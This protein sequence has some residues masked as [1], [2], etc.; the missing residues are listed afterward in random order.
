MRSKYLFAVA[1][2]IIFSFIFYVMKPGKSAAEQVLDQYRT[3]IGAA[4]R[5][6]KALYKCIKERAAVDIIRNQFTASREAYKK[7]E[8]LAEYY[9]SYTTRY[10]NGPPLKEVEADAK[11]III[12]PEGFQVIEELIYPAY[13]SSANQ[14][15]LNEV[16]MLS[17]NIKRLELQAAYIETTD[18]HIFDALRLQVFRMIS[19][20]LSGFDS[21]LAKNSLNE[22]ASTLESI[23][24][25]Y[26]YYRQ[27][28]QRKNKAL[29]ESI[30]KLLLS[31]RKLLAASGDFNTFDRADFIVN[32]ANPLSEYLLTAQSQLG[33]PFFKEPR[34]LLSIAPTLFSERVFNPD[35][36]VSGFANH[37]SAAKVQLGE[38]LFNDVKLSGNGKV[39]CATCHQPGRAFTDG[40][41]TSFSI[42]GKDHLKRNAPTLINAALQASLFYDSRVAFLEDQANEVL[43]NKDE[44]HGSFESIFN[45]IDKDKGLKASFATAFHTDVVTEQHVKNAIAAYLRSLISLNAK[46]DLYMR[47]HRPAMSK[48]ELKG[49]NLFMGKAK[50]ATCHFVPL[51]NGTMPPSFTKTEAE[52]IGAP[53]NRDTVNAVLDSDPGK[54]VLHQIPLHMNA[55]KTPGLRNIE[56]TAP[57]MHNGVY[58]T[59]EE[60]IDFYDR[61]GGGGLGFEMDNLTLAKAALQLSTDEKKALVAFLKCLTDTKV[62]TK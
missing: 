37:S 60:V 3:D 5:Q 48:E 21:P 11:D 34:A 43:Q 12:S 28:L 54:Y 27:K 10:I 4:D 18:A 2:I 44:M 29:D 47:G 25:N 26:S 8:W 7:T 19:L 58:K 6:V 46:F 33:I 57:Y 24:V 40:M 22:A 62:Y 38:R 39:S 61:G 53:A 15:L 1:S 20:G 31:A 23:D 45:H 49:F 36:Y 41:M 9:N 13:D 59:L 17:L 56:L 14:D 30:G 42:N 16:N 51:F 32:F 50:C 35:Y 52:V 55:F